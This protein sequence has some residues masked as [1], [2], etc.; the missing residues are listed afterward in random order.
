[1]TLGIL[2]FMM[3]GAAD[4]RTVSVHARQV[5]VLVVLLVV[6]AVRAVRSG[7]VMLAQ[8]WPDPF[9]ADDLRALE[10]YRQQAT[11]DL[12]TA[13][14]DGEVLAALRRSSRATRCGAAACSRTRR[15]R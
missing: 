9:E 10:R 5:L 13:M 11:E 6:S 4:D 12:Q 1:M 7:S 8:P 2:C 15:P 14:D 3:G